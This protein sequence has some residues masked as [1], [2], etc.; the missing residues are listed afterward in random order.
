MAQNL[1]QAFYKAVDRYLEPQG[2]SDEEIL[3]EMSQKTVQKSVTKKKKEKVD[4]FVEDERKD[5]DA[6]KQDSP[7]RKKKKTS[8]SSTHPKEDIQP[9]KKKVEF[10]KSCDKVDSLVQKKKVK[11]S[12]LEEGNLDIKDRKKDLVNQMSPVKKT[13]TDMPAKKNS[14]VKVET[15]Y[16]DSE[17]S[18]FDK[19]YSKSKLNKLQSFNKTSK[20]ETKDVDDD[21][22]K[23]SRRGWPKGR[24]RK[25]KGPGRPKIKTEDSDMQEEDSDEEEHEHDKSQKR[26]PGRPKAKNSNSKLLKTEKKDEILEDVPK[27]EYSDSDHYIDKPE[28]KRGPGRPR[29]NTNNTKTEEAS[30]D[31]EE[32]DRILQRSR[33]KANMYD[34]YDEDFLNSEEEVYTKK[35]TERTKKYEDTLFKERESCKK[36]KYSNDTRNDKSKQKKRGRKKK[37]PIEPKPPDPEEEDD[38]S[39]SETEILNKTDQIRSKYGMPIERDKFRKNSNI[40]SQKTKNFKSNYEY[41]SDS[42]NDMEDKY[43]SKNIEDKY[44][45]KNKKRKGHKQSG[46]NRY[47]DEENL[48][49]C[50]SDS[51]FTNKSKFGDERTSKKSGIYSHN[52]DF[53]HMNN[54]KV[55]K[56]SERSK[57]KIKPQHVVEDE[58]SDYD[59][60]KIRY[61]KYMNS[62]KYWEAEGFAS[63]SDDSN[64]STKNHKLHYNE[65]ENLASITS[66][67]VRSDSKKMKHDMTKNNKKKKKLPDK[68]IDGLNLLE[69]ATESALK[70][71]P[72]ISSRLPSVFAF[73]FYYRN[74]PV[75]AF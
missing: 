20:K 67:S 16:T 6:I 31:K 69:A 55:D 47:S 7:E 51:Y 2:S 59:N 38:V 75:V 24:P 43:N 30:I 26:K 71:S 74:F 10:D 3:I 5:F 70:V 8:K 25:K 29:K 54:E 56:Y 34:S 21:E 62:T 11:K 32:N 48:R 36:T 61:S 12:F 18:D 9:L 50:P 17:A 37:V 49:D 15:V 53:K 40:N 41:Q 45:K 65:K 46:H 57:I 60:Q 35:H 68:S 66:N 22:D 14:K 13:S 4:D 52:P 28:V 63:D 23:Q 33:N 1:E 19:D 39:S 42:G 27:S 44:D 73:K 64:E 72:V 58:D